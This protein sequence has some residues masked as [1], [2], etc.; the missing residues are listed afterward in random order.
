LYDEPS[1]QLLLL[2]HN[3]MENNVHAIQ[4]HMPS[5][6]FFLERRRR[7]ALH[8]IKKKKGKIPKYKEQN[9]TQLNTPHTLNPKGLFS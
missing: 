4:S 6:D 2:A 1:K 3:I 5:L 7:T 9:P 8:Y